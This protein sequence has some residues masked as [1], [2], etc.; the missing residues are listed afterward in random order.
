MKF[1]EIYLEGESLY[2]V[3][4]AFCL[5]VLSCIEVKVERKT[6]AYAVGCDTVKRG[7]VLLAKQFFL[8]R[9]GVFII[10]GFCGNAVIPTSRHVACRG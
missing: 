10:L 7:T 5:I 3:L 1:Y 9:D 8:F 4:A 6:C 2:F